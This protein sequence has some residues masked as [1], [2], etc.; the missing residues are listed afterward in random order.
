MAFGI[1]I[2]TMVWYWYVLWRE[3]RRG[4]YIRW[5]VECGV[6]HI[7]CV[8]LRRRERSILG[9]QAYGHWGAVR[10][11]GSVR[12]GVLASLLLFGERADMEASHQPGY[13]IEIR[14]NF[15]DQFIA[16]KIQS[17]ANFLNCSKCLLKA[18]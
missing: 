4:F 2:F 16:N 13:L 18:Q 7:G 5:E 17:V 12:D 1:L 9:A 14:A 6:D 15:Y 10:L 3:R 8:R 11:L